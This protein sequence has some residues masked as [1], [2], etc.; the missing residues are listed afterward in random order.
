MSVWTWT[1]ML[2]STHSLS[3]KLPDSY[4][5]YI[6][7]CTPLTFRKTSKYLKHIPGSHSHTTVLQCGQY[8]YTI[9]HA[10]LTPVMGNS[11]TEVRSQ[12]QLSL[13]KNVMY[14]SMCWFHLLSCSTIL[15]AVVYYIGQYSHIMQHVRPGPVTG[16]SKTKGRNLCSSPT[17][18]VYLMDPFKYLQMTQH[19]V[20]PTVE[21]IL[22]LATTRHL[23]RTPHCI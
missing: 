20:L 19:T 12:Y 6:V 9:K 18:N 11:Y 5:L 14:H 7:E 8:G 1:S 2:K 23:E 15:V 21:Q 16:N 13:H 17:Y 3:S 22:K 10:R 4:A